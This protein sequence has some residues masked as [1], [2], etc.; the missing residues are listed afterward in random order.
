MTTTGMSAPPMDD[1]I[2]KPRAPLERTPVVKA[3][4]AKVG[5]ED[6]QK[7]RKDIYCWN[8]RHK[9]RYMYVL[10]QGW[11]KLRILNS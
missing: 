11:V 8:A 6:T 9:K 5:S 7:A 3:K 1:V 4:D 10:N 2:C